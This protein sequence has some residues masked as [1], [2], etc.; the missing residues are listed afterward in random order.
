MIAAKQFG[1]VESAALAAALLTERDPFRIQGDNAR[2]PVDRRAERSDSD[3]IDRVEQLVAYFDGDRR[4]PIN[5]PA[6]KQIRRVAQQLLNTSEALVMGGIDK[7]ISD[8]DERDQLRRA[9]LDAFP[10]RVARRRQPGSD[11]GLMVGGRGVKV[12]RQ[13]TVQSADYFLCIDVDG[14]GTEGFVRSASAIETD[15]LDER[16]IREVDETFFQPSAQSVAT[17][18]RRYF[19]DLLLS[20]SPIETKP[21][22]QVASLI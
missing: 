14:K 13:S 2:S 20:E 6:A 9:L 3:I 5:A 10:D 12:D 17:R 4:R 7:S 18:R 22:G 15:W 19:D 21:G 11:R 1:V 16:L 8:A